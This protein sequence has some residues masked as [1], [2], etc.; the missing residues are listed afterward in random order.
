VNDVTLQLLFSS[1][2]LLVAFLQFG[3][4]GYL[5]LVDP[6]A[7]RQRFLALLL[8]VLA[9][10]SL[11]DNLLQSAFTL[12]EATPW[13][14]LHLATFTA[15]GPLLF[16]TGLATLRPAWLK[17]YPLSYLTILG[18][19]LLP[20]LALVFD[21]TG[22]SQRLFEAPLF[23][24]LPTPAEFSNG[25]EILENADAGRLHLVFFALHLGFSALA[26]I[27]P[28]LLVLWQDRS[29][30]PKNSRI[31]FFFFL[32]TLLTALLQMNI[33][34]L[35][36]AALATTITSLLYFSLALYITF[37]HTS[38]DEQTRQIQKVFRTWS[39]F[40]KLMGVITVIVVMISL[41]VGLTTF[42]VV[43]INTLQ[44]EGRKLAVLA[45]AETRNI[46]DEF[47]NEI[48]QLQ[49]LAQSQQLITTVNLQNR[50]YTN[51]ASE[52]IAEEIARREL[53]W[54][55][56]TTQTLITQ[57]LERYP[58]TYEALQE[59]QALTPANQLIYLADTHG[60][61]VTGTAPP[62][63]YNAQE[64]SWWQRV[65]TGT[66]ETIYISPL[67]Y[68]R[69]GQQY[70]VEIALPIHNALNELQ[71]VLYAR[72]NI[73]TLLNRVTNIQF[74]ETG[75][76]AF[77]NA[78][79]FQL[80]DS[81]DQP[82]LDTGLNWDF[83][84]TLPQAWQVL[85]YSDEARLIAWTEMGDLYPEGPLA[86]L[87]WRIVF[88]QST[89]EIL[90]PIRLI[91]LTSNI[92]LLGTVL[93]AIF[94]AGVLARILTYPLN[95]LTQNAALIRQGNLSI[96][97]EELTD[98][99]FGTLA[100]AFNQMT[101]QI[102]SLISNLENQVDERTQ[103]LQQRAN[104]IR[105][106]VDIGNTVASLR[107]INELLPQITQLVSERFG[108]YHVGIFLISEDQQYAVLRAANSP[109]GRRMLARH[110]QLKIG[111]TGIVGYVA[112]Q[113]LPR[114]ALDVGEDA[115]Y[116]NN[117]DLPQ[118]RSEMALPIL[119]AGNLIG[120]LDVQSTQPQAFTQEDIS[121]LQLLADQLAVAIEN[122]HLFASNQSA[123]AE[124]H[125]ALEATRRA[126]SDLSR[127]GWK[128][129]ARESRILA[130]RANPSGLTPVRDLPTPG[131]TL[132]AR[133]GQPTRPA[134]GTLALPIKIQDHVAGVIQLKKEA[135]EN[136]SAKEINFIETIVS[137][138][139]TAIESARLY[140]ETQ[141]ALI[142][143]EALYQV[144]RAAT[145]YARTEDLLLAVADTIAGT[146]PA[147]RVLISTLDIPGEKVLQFIENHAAPQEISPT[148]FHAL[149]NGLTGWAITHRKSVLSPKGYPDPREDLQA[150]QHRQEQGIGP[151]IV[152]PMFY[153]ERAIGTLTAINQ[154]DDADYTND[155]VELLSA[156]SNQ[157]AA[158]LTNAELLIQTRQH[159]LQLQT[160]AEISRAVTSILELKQLLPQIVELIRSRFDF[161]YAGLFLVDETRSWAILRAGTG[162]AGTAQ[163]AANY[164]LPLDA[165]NPL[166]QCLTTNQARIVLD[167]G[168]DAVSFAN[169]ALPATRSEMIL[170]LTSRTRTLG[171]LSIQSD[172]P[173]AFNAD[174]LGVFQTMA[175]QIA[176]AVDNAI[177]FETNSRQLATST[178]LLEI[179]QVVST[180]IQLDQILREI[181]I[182]TAKVTQA[183]RCIVFLLD[184]NLTLQPA[185]LQFA[186]GHTDPKQWE[187]LTSLSGGPLSQNPLF[188]EAIRLR[189][190]VLVT[191]AQTHTDLPSLAW[192]KAL[193]Q[194]ALLCI[195]MISQDR[196]IGLLVLDQISPIHSFVREQM[197]LATT[198]AGQA[199]AI[200]Q[201]ARLY[202]EQERRSSD[203]RKLNEF[204]LELSQT[205]MD[206]APAIETLSHR[207]MELMDSDGGG[208]W[209]W[210]EETKELELIMA[211]QAAGAALAG[212][213][214][215]EGEGLAGKCFH[216]R[217]LEVVEDYASWAGH[218]AVF[219]Q[220]PIH[221]ALAVPLIQQN[222][223]L[224]VLI[225]NRSQPNRPYTLDQQNLAL[226]L[227]S[228]AAAFIRTAR[229]FQQTQEAL[230]REQRERRLADILARAAE[231]F[232]LAHGEH[233]LRQAMLQEIHDVVLPDQITLYE[234]VDE[235]NA[236]KV[237]LR[238]TPGGEE[239]N[240]A[241]GQ[242]LGPDLRSDLWQAFSSHQPLYNALHLSDGTQKEH[243]ILPWLSGIQTCGV[244]ELF[245]T[246]LHVHI[247]EQDQ[248]AIRGV[249]R[250]AA[251][252]IQSA[253]LF[254]QTQEALTHTEALYQVSQASTAVES[255]GTLLQD[256]VDRIA[257]SLPADRVLLITLDLESKQVTSFVESGLP[258]GSIVPLAYDELMSGLTGWV[259]QHRK[260][261]LSPKAQKDDRETE[262]VYQHRLG[263]GS[264]SAIVVPLLYRDQIFG[265]L[266]A[267]NE[268][269][270]PDF[271]IDDVNLLAA[272]ANQ[273]A[274][275]IENARLFNQTQ[276]RALLLQTAAEV[277]NAASSILEL[278]Q[279]LPEV[280][281]LIRDR[282]NLYYV[283][284]FLVDEIR[285][286]AVLRA[287]T[288]EAGRV[289]IEQGHRL[290]L[291]I[292]SMIGRCILEAQA[293]IAQEIA[294]DTIFFKNPY[295][296]ETRSELALPL[297]ASGQT[298][299]AMTI[300]SAQPLAFSRDDITVLGTLADQLAVA[301]ENARFVADTR[302]RAENEQ[303]L[304]QITAQLSHSLD[305]ETILQTAVTEIGHLSRVREVSIHFGNEQLAL[306]TEALLEELTDSQHDLRLSPAK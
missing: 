121:I 154:T 32:A 119:S 207:A 245:H 8:L 278:N 184:E 165:S 23:I 38:F 180:S 196:A 148:L 138:L 150:Q 90:A 3:L 80:P 101:A 229:L 290:R 107:D 98:D 70:Y 239:D 218:A 185:T 241:L 213:R 15:I 291:N 9:L 142:R 220:I 202:Q 88:S 151:I 58:P 69:L 200:I 279:L 146:L 34:P 187:V 281:E 272:M 147:R 33:L 280:V 250:Q 100:T 266:T 48:I 168:L 236:F 269:N 24:L 57:Y 233:A 21:L 195:P 71:G 283:G 131:E 17:K 27:F 246:A 212:T 305:L 208:L 22:L 258:T 248:E 238:L 175:E 68:D 74:G 2:L 293:Q 36:N 204:S 277:S 271:S 259:I 306:E 19:S 143:T 261:A 102:Q 63:R 260:P 152:V 126:Y 13:I 215:K 29:S 199:A 289:Q 137:Q 296:P 61:I 6:R 304:N 194:Q 254:E 40:A 177:L 93:V 302:I 163:I 87:Q 255:L 128:N 210:L 81:P 94:L 136:W 109:G 103:T 141:S 49:E 216:S 37:L 249:I 75:K 65:S 67:F 91:S 155:D 205:Q 161:Y 265:T 41:A 1:F 171:A 219:T 124:S 144:G 11:S 183:Y 188:A 122:A 156:M 76:A 54:Q 112:K 189:Q 45:M 282:F 182:R 83:L 179:T 262:V 192:L 231:K 253:R 43:R 181:T 86:N 294:S 198:I 186:D 16:L 78:L 47:L 222:E 4:A 14:A 149:M 18:L 252:A 240:Y 97:A 176:S 20:A 174:D 273:A 129:L 35:G 62:E 111:E 64:F 52:T 108:F 106:A 46:G 228:Q 300:Q 132:T 115:S 84:N 299:G 139:G 288:D 303:L 133:T 257:E 270:N 42:T 286:Y 157:L 211:F 99:E 26:L 160:S 104:Q 284:L 92:V 256:I 114:I 295:L 167:V 206:L 191:N 39:V 274:A 31:A 25:L 227:A 244:V 237:D 125:A 162:E 7:L 95:K 173:V 130:Y 159:A 170:P 172:L 110:H 127:E 105:A 89:Q 30:D 77:F 276:R 298:L 301:I 117:P 51:V 267:T 190:P 235:T 28:A 221:A 275:A 145:S 96:R 60:V 197:D 72:Y 297:T 55:R 169:S 209:F 56:T 140:K 292:Q 166:G 85:P 12:R 10:T 53:E 44:S 178:T 234:W 116:F 247:R 82:P 226:L 287:G 73:Q 5:L 203:L 223:T 120:V 263:A 285:R 225:L 268:L 113:K 242:L 79:G 123:L 193:H 243:L 251:V 158:A 134:P 118:T 66:P 224:G 153:Q 264:G 217:Q 214:L 201:N 135:Q 230:A 59:F 50:Q 164:R 232:G